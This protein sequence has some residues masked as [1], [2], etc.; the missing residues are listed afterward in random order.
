MATL[1][2]DEIT[3]SHSTMTVVIFDDL[4]KIHFSRNIINAS[5]EAR[6]SCYQLYSQGTCHV[7]RFWSWSLTQKR[8]IEVTFIFIFFISHAALKLF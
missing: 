7:I 2:S 3:K 4:I 6:Q 8:K 1:H 5:F